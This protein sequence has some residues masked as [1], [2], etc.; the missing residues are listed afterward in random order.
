MESEFAKAIEIISAKIVD[1]NYNMLFAKEL[2]TFEK[3]L[4]VKQNMTKI[5]LLHRKC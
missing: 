4:K 3:F 1:Y 5:Q 2:Q